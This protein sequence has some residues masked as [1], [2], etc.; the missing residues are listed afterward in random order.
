MGTHSKHST[1]FLEYLERSR[2][3]HCV[4][5][6][7]RSEDLKCLG[8]KRGDYSK[9]DAD[10]LATPG[11]RVLGDDIIIGRTSPLPEGVSERESGPGAPEKKDSQRLIF[12]PRSTYLSSIGKQTRSNYT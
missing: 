6:R 9:L 12:A 2:K 11:S 4:V 3:C 10:G 8:S 7:L 5:R 1:C